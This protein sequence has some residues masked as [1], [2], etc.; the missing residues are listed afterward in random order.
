MD[1]L[2]ADVLADVHAGTGGYE[3]C[4]RQQNEAWLFPVMLL[5]GSIRHST[6]RRARLARMIS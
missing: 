5:V 4:V 1:K 3:V 2:E 6:K